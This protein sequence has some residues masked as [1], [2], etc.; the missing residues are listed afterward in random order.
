MIFAASSTTAD[1]ELAKAFAHTAE[2]ARHYENFTVVSWLLPRSLRPHFYNV[3]AF[4]R[5]ADDLADEIA[6]SQESLRLLNE[7]AEDVGRMYGGR[8]NNLILQALQATVRQFDIPAE[9]FL[10]LIDAFVQDQRVKRYESFSDLRDYCRRSADPVG[11]LVLYLCGYGDEH[12]QGLADFTCTALQLA[13]FWQDVSNDLDRGRIYVPLEDLRRF[14]VS[15]QQVVDRRFDP[16][17]ANLMRFE[18]ERTESLFR[19]GEALLPLVRRRVRTDL[20]LYG[21]GGRAILQSIRDIGYNTLQHRPTLS[22]MNKLSL[23]LGYLVGL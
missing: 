6:D 1:H 10:K 13:N 5:H 18:L 16:A 2:M 12:R 19:Q 17:F 20:A 9:P 3:Y 21:R 14:G 7:L 15:E 8:P 22:R 11:H 23:L 4:C